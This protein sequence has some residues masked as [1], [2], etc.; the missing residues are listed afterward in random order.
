MVL[1]FEL[2]RGLL[3]IGKFSAK[4]VDQ[5]QREQEGFEEEEGDNASPGILGLLWLRSSRVGSCCPGD[6]HKVFLVIALEV[7][8]LRSKVQHGS[9]VRLLL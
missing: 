3:P 4:Q 6:R 8:Y 2:L 5:K 1:P 7:V 9:M